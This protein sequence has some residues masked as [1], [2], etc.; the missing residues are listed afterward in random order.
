MKRA[1]AD[2]WP[3]HAIVADSLYGETETVRTGLDKLKVGDG[4]ALKPSHYWWHVEGE[5]G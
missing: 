2:T 5:L 3:C 4:L 1:V